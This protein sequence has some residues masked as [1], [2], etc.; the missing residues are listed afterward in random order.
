MV[1]RNDPRVVYGA[2]CTWWDS[3]HKVAKTDTD[4]P[5]PCCPHCGSVLFETENEASWFKSI[6]HYEASGHPGY[7]AMMEWS[8]GRCFKGLGDLAKAYRGQGGEVKL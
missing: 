6:D 5:I 1:A 4:P 2:R 7:R 8:R 3:I